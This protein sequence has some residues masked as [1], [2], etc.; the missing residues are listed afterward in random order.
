VIRTE[1]DVVLLVDAKMT[2]LFTTILSS[3]VG[4][5]G[6]VSRVS[7]MI[8]QKTVPGT[9]FGTGSGILEPVPCYRFL[10]Q[11]T[12]NYTEF[13]KDTGVVPRFLDFCKFQFP[14]YSKTNRQTAVSRTMNKNNSVHKYADKK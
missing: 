13:G 4:R 12:T 5:A 10:R 2:A 7:V 1:V 11:I 3:R 14:F 9:G 6:R 8:S